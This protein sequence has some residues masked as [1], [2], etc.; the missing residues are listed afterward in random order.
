MAGSRKDGLVG[1]DG[2]IE[3]ENVIALLNVLAPPVVFDIFLQ[4]ST[5]R[6]VIPASVEAAV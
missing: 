2:A 6:A 4:V 3:S 5:E 1:E